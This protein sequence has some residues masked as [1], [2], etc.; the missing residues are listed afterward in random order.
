MRFGISATSLMCPKN[1][2]TR[3]RPVNV[4]CAIV[5]SH[6][7]APEERTFPNPRLSKS[8][9]G[10]EF[11]FVLR[12]VRLSPGHENP[13][14]KYPALKNA[15]RRTGRSNAPA[16]QKPFRHGLQSP[17]LPISQRLALKPCGLS[18]EPCFRAAVPIWDG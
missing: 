18:C 2:R 6:F 11:R 7:V 8:R 14:S 12:T 9:F 16:R 3:L 15:K 4:C 17:K 1:L 10:V 13:E 5:A